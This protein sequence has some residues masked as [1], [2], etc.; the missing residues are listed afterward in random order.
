MKKNKIIKKFQEAKIVAHLID[1]CIMDDNLYWLKK[2]TKINRKIRNIL[3][4]YGD[5]YRSKVRNFFIGNAISRD[6]DSKDGFVIKLYGHEKG[7]TYLNKM[8]EMLNYY[9]KNT[10]KVEINVINEISFAKSHQ[11]DGGCVN[12]V[13]HDT[14]VIGVT[15]NHIAADFNNKKPNSKIKDSL[16]NIVGNLEDYVPLIEYNPALFEESINY[17]D[18]A[19][20]SPLI[21]NVKPYNYTKI[22]DFKKR[23]YFTKNTLKVYIG[24]SKIK[25]TITAVEGIFYLEY[26]KV[27]YRFED[28][29]FIDKGQ[30]GYSGAFLTD[31][32]DNVGG[33]VFGKTND[34]RGLVSTFKNINC[35]SKSSKYRYN[36]NFS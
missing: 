29:I 30:P 34:D 27:K 23:Y 13:K 1:K 24:S 35:F 25:C 26:N 5:E 21:S 20:V 9:L 32:N 33:M 8:E 10:L 19:W 16:G 2:D 12:W 28:I 18:L 36:L 22:V 17:V 14:E 11:V 7:L 15:C 31:S 6:N 3:Y 4:D